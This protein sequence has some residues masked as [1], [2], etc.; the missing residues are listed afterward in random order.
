MARALPNPYR[1]QFTPAQE[2]EMEAAQNEAE[3][4]MDRLYGEWSLNHRSDVAPDAFDMEDG[5][6]TTLRLSRIGGGRWRFNELLIVDDICVGGSQQIHDK[7]L[8]D[9]LDEKAESQ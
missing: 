6:G 9:W 1:D 4:R 5:G 7:R 2:A 3:R 8:L